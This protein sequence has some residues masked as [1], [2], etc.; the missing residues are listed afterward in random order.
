VGT[1]DEHVEAGGAG[2]GGTTGD[3]DAPQP[4]I[5]GTIGGTAGADANSEAS[6]LSKPPW[7]KAYTLVPKGTKRAA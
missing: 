7:R 5:G 6:T 3:V 4:P 2:L 1:P